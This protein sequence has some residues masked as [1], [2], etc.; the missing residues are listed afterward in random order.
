MSQPA[1]A[2]IT[3]QQVK[4]KLSEGPATVVDIRDA[5]SFAAAR[6][7]NAVRVD[8]NNLERFIAETP[9]DVPL[10]VYCYH[11]ITSQPAADFFRNQGFAEVYSMSGGYAL[12]SRLFPQ[13]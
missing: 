5:R 10:I 1:I 8:N 13:S 3:P 2:Q 4:Q 7:P 12:W 11:G 6:V 9:T